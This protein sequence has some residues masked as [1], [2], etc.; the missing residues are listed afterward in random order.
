M[1]GER[2]I[3]NQTSAA[4]PRWAAEQTPVM[5]DRTVVRLLAAAGLRPAPPGLAGRQK[6]GAR[7]AAGGRLLGSRIVAALAKRQCA[8]ARRRDKT[9]GVFLGG[10][11]TVVRSKIRYLTTRV[12]CA[13]A[14][15]GSRAWLLLACCVAWP[16]LALAR[17]PS[18]SPPTPVELAPRS[19]AWPATLRGIWYWVDPQKC[20]L[21][22]A[23]ARAFTGEFSGQ[24]RLFWGPFLGRLI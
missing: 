22:H 9:N 13:T 5:Q 12:A 10:E 23:P 18:L 17:P 11:N 2:G 1:D 8:T 4:R 7:V 20:I 15:P 3:A 21:F 24:A 6:V 16:G 14:L 19:C